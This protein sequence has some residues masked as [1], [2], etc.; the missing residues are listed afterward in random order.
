VLETLCLLRPGATACNA[1]SLSNTW[2][3]PDFE[4]I[5]MIPAWSCSSAHAVAARGSTTS[6]PI[7]FTAW[8]L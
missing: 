4:P 8:I 1:G 5:A 2:V 3:I 6:L 7:V